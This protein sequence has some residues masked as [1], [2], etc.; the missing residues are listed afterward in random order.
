MSTRRILVRLT[1]IVLL[2]LLITSCKQAS[3]TPAGTG[4]V[5]SSPPVTP[6]EAS[7]SPTAVTPSA[8]PIPLAATVNGEAISLDD[9]QAELARYNASVTITGTILA[10]D[11]KSTV[12]ND[13]IDQTLLSQA[14]IQDGF[15][16]DDQMLNERI[17][18]LENQVG[19]SQALQDWKTAQGY[20]D[21]QFRRALKRSIEAAWMRDQVVGKVP[22]T[23][24]MV[25]IL[26]ILLPTAK[27]A[28]QVYSSLRT[29]ADFKELART[30]DPLTGGDLGWFG[31]GYLDDPA[32]EQAAFSLGT[33]QFSP[34]IETQIGF[35][36]LYL[37]EKDE[38]HPLQPD[39]RQALQAAAIKD[40]LVEQRKT[41]EITIFLP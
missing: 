21:E 13:L 1:L 8:T 36:I 26:Q 31:R 7:A 25:H 2:P 23:A 33:G 3:V 39:A 11:T 18:T 20:D 10:S 30:Y 29:G 4:S 37:L 12:L 27:E 38:N 41:S 34:V 15:I 14:A 16:V 35:H 5:S 24:E 28:E 40:W 19:G 17:A 32:I 6:V 22:E 9:F